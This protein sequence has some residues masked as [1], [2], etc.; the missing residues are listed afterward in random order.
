MPPIDSHSPGSFC[1]FELGTTDQAGA[2][3]FYRGLFGW[4]SEDSPMGQDMI[5]TMFRLNDRDVAATYTLSQ[6]VRDRG[7]PAH[8][9]PYIAVKS[10]DE[11][12]ERIRANGGVIEAPPFEVMTFGRMAVAKDPAGAHFSIWQAKDHAGTG[13][14]GENG[15]ACWQDLVTPDPDAAEKFYKAVFGWQFSGDKG[16][17]RHIQNGE[18][19]IGGLQTP[20]EKT[21]RIPPHWLTYFQ[22]ADAD[23][24]AA[25]AQSLGGNVRIPPT[26][27]PGA[28]RFALIFDPQ[29][30]DFAVFKP[31]R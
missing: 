16:E 1:W 19:Y 4:M 14:D 12:V 8:W 25:K 18:Q 17:Y 11:T 24:A 13:I 31:F 9:M 15:T 27:A 5:Y 26:D 30:A 2:K 3:A 10:A 21:K 23:A 20:N 6:E 28:G 7:V 22:V 29:G